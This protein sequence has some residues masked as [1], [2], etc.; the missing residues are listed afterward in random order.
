[1][2]LG[3][4][5]AGTAIADFNEVATKL[6]LVAL[7]VNNS[8]NLSCPHCYLQYA[9]ID[10]LIAP[11]DVDIL[12]KQDFKHL[13]IV[14]MEP[15][16]NPI[17]AARTCWIAEQASSHGKSVS[18]ITN[19][20]GLNHLSREQIGLFDFFDISF[21]GGPN[22][23]Q[24]FRGA[25]YDRLERNLLDAAN[26]GANL[27]A[28]HVLYQENLEHIEDMISIEGQIPLNRVMFSPYMISKNDGTNGVNELG[29]FE[30]LRALSKEQSFLNDDKSFF[31]IDQY[32]LDSL[33]LDKEY[34]LSEILSLDIRSKIHFVPHSP[35][36]VGTIRATYDG[37]LLSPSDA[38]NPAEYK[39]RGIPI[40]SET[41]DNAYKIFLAD[42][43]TSY[44]NRSFGLVAAE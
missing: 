10:K 9:G 1:M 39:S 27:N 4:L 13:A 33:G 3:G 5:V 42:E 25:S 14:G 31:I 19:G 28:I 30:I 40:Q 17:S 2:A 38:L 11:G 26:L 37:L 8:C 44:A 43:R 20:M 16:L 15:F 36:Q 32:H 6:Q 12:I 21:D 34:V 29:L 18:V 7:T 35:L 23:Y 41:L 24:L 22:S